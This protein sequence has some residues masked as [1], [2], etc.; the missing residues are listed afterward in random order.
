ME[1]LVHTY[2]SVFG[3]QERLLQFLVYIIEFSL[4]CRKNG[5]SEE[6]Q[7]YTQSTDYQL[8]PVYRTD[9]T[10]GT[11]SMEGLLLFCHSGEKQFTQILAPRCQ[12]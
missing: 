4:H 10:T 8:F 7:N 5:L 1:V 6:V 3:I 9:E 12:N 2:I 11:E